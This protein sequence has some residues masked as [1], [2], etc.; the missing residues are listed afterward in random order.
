VGYFVYAMDSAGRLH[1]LCGDAE[2]GRVTYL[3]PNTEGWT[4][5]EL[6]FQSDNPSEYCTPGGLYIASDGTVYATFVGVS[7]LDPGRGTQLALAI[8]RPDNQ[9]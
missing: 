7:R 2:Q 9:G 8:L 3:E 5:H 4:T 1:M 6:A